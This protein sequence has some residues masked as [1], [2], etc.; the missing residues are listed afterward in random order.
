MCPGRSLTGKKCAAKPPNPGWI[1]YIDICNVIGKASPKTQAR[2]PARPACA[3]VSPN[4]LPCFS[5]LSP[6]FVP[7]LF[8]V[9][10]RINPSFVQSI[11]YISPEYI[12]YKTWLPVW[13]THWSTVSVYETYLL[14]I[15]DFR[16]LKQTLL[17]HS[18][19][20]R[21]RIR[22]NNVWMIISVSPGYCIIEWRPLHG[23]GKNIDSLMLNSPRQTIHSLFICPPTIASRRNTRSN[24]YHHTTFQALLN[25]KPVNHQQ[26]TTNN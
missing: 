14:L 22:S 26:P 17:N 25:I 15:P 19:G 23:Q 4:F 16:A 5:Q 6:K 3:Q 18:K 2:P 1:P 12:L 11:S 7:T 24:F 9:W 20:T 10:V 13:I 21:T 8:Q